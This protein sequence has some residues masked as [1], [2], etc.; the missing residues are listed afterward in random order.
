MNRRPLGLKLEKAVLGF[1][2]FKT[3]EGLSSNTLLSVWVSHIR[4][5]MQSI[6]PP[7]FE[8]GSSNP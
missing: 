2:Q 3:A 5:S 1:L 6:P 8:D 4:L 7:K